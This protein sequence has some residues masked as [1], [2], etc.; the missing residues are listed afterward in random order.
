MASGDTKTEA[1][2]S[3]LE[4]GGDISNVVGCCNT[5]LQNYIIGSIDSLDSAKQI[6]EQKGGTVGDTGLSGLAEE[7]ASIPSGG[8]GDWGTVTYLDDNNVEQTVKIQNAYEYS[9]LGQIDQ[10]NL[11]PATISD[12]TIPKNKITKIVVGKDADYSPYGFMLNAT[13]LNSLTG[14]ENWEHIEAYCLQGCKLEHPIDLSN[15]TT[16]EVGFMSGSNQYNQPVSLPKVVTIGNNFLN[17][18]SSFDSQVTF[19]DSLTSVGT[20]FLYNCSSFNHQIIF[21]DSLKTIGAGFMNICVSFNSAISLGGVETIGSNFMTGCTAFAQS[22][23]IPAT[24]SDNTATIGAPFM[25]NCNNFTGPLV[26]NAPTRNQALGSSTQTLATTDSTAPM[27]ATGVTLSGPYA[28]IW[29]NR[30]SNRTSSPY[31]NLTV[32]S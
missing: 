25:Y 8:S 12:I 19:S 1:L 30:Y 17:G 7:I 20:N 27:Y 22:L 16:V 21:P 14:T 29:K 4:N 3:A 15:V 11:N 18:C 10:S 24:I 9:T 28:S 32:Q 6:I 26:C 31:R 5:N 2:L 13:N 23:T